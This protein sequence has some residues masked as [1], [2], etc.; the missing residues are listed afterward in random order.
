MEQRQALRNGHAKAD[1]S[2]APLESSKIFPISRPSD[3]THTQFI[4]QQAPFIRYQSVSSRAFS[5]FA[6]MF[7]ARRAFSTAQR[8]AFSASARQ[9][10]FLL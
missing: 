6:I 8:R 7:A 10:A 3:I 9:V 4:T 5:A 2:T 1:G